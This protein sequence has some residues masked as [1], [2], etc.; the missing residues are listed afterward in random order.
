MKEEILEFLS[1]K[2][3]ASTAEVAKYIG[4]SKNKALKKLKQLS[5][6]NLVS[7]IGKIASN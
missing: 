3:Y 5:N 2:E 4:K 7:I 1:K 6:K